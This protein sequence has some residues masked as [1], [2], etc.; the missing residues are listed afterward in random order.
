MQAEN[1]FRKILMKIIDKKHFDFRSKSLT[2][3]ESNDNKDFPKCWKK[4]DVYLHCYARLGTMILT[5]ENN[6]LSI[7]LK[8]E[9]ENL[10]PFFHADFSLQDIDKVDFNQIQ[11]QFCF[12][13]HI[14][15]NT[16]NELMENFKLIYFK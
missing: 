4:F 1:E 15:N 11:L 8:E 3:F 13:Y 12:Y 14:F 7:E 9:N 6:R 16:H 10:H 2:T 5:Y